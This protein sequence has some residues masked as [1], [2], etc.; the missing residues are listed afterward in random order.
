MNTA[1]MMKIK[2]QMKKMVD[3]Y[4]KLDIEKAQLK[5]D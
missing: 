5:K 3:D 4:N 1:E 2:L